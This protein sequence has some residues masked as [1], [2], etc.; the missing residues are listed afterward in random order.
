MQRDMV[1][2]QDERMLKV[3]RVVGSGC[4]AGCGRTVVFPKGL[5]IVAKTASVDGNVRPLRC[6]FDED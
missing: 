1:I 4:H 3:P 2:K 5:I 6:H